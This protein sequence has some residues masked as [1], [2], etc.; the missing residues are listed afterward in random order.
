MENIVISLIVCAVCFALF[1]MFRGL[2]IQ[3]GLYMPIYFAPLL[4]V[5]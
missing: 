4:G 5:L 2:W 3:A 1:V